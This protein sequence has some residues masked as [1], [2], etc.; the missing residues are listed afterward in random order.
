MLNCFNHHLQ[1][2]TGLKGTYQLLATLMI[3]ISNYR[4]SLTNRLRAV[5]GIAVLYVFERGWNLLFQ[6]WNYGI[7]KTFSEP[8][9]LPAISKASFH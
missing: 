7:N 1:K 3:L 6:A 8:S 4:G 9:P 5:H 2:S